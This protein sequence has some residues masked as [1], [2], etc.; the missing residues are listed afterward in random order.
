MTHETTQSSDEY[1]LDQKRSELFR[2]ESEL[3]DRELELT[4]LQHDLAAFEMGYLRVVGKRYAMLDDI[5]ARIALLRSA[6]QPNDDEVHEQARSMRE[7]AEASASQVKGDSPLGDNDPALPFNPSPSVKALYRSLSRR[8]HPDLASDDEDRARRNE[9][10]A[11]V[12]NA[13]QQQQENVLNT[14]LHDWETSPDAVAG[15]GTAA[16][17]VRTRRRIDQVKQRFDEIAIAIADIKNRDLYELYVES[18]IQLRA[19]RDMLQELAA[20]VDVQISDAKTT[21]EE[22][23]RDAR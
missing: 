6:R 9:W 18:T 2:L 16:E 12:N 19:G 17:L 7:A 21:L 13:Y 8:V 20:T 14:L 22:L 11:R 1:E 23:E 10:M 3:V 4:T 5:R 15:N